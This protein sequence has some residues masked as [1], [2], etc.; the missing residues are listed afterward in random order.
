MLTWYFCYSAKIMIN[1]LV[2]Y[3]PVIYVII[4]L[5]HIAKRRN[6]M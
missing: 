1:K 4:P 3:K 2:V 6:L 5:K